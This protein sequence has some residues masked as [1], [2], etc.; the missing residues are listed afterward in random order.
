MSDEAT[1][2]TTQEVT[3]NEQV[4]TE[5]TDLNGSAY[6]FDDLDSLTETRNS[7]ELVDDAKQF[8][9]KGDATETAAEEGKS[10]VPS[11]DSREEKEAT[12][13]ED[14]AEDE[15]IEEIKYRQGKYGE[16]EQQIAEDTI[17]SQKIE[18]EEV[19]VSLKDLL[20][21]YA[22]KVP[23]DKRFNE[24]NV[25]KKE[26]EKSKEEY[27]TEKEYIN[28]YI[29]E[30][31]NKMREGK[32]VEALGFLAEF[33]GM[34]PYEF[35]QQL[36][37]NLAPEVDRRRTLSQDQLSNE[38]LQEE[39]KYLEQVHEAERQNNERQQTYMELE[40]KISALQ[41]TYDISDDDFDDAYDELKE[42]D[43]KD[44]LNP[45]LIVNYLRH[46]NAFTRADVVINEVQP[47]LASNQYVVDAIE[48][49]IF[50]N[51]EFTKEQVTGIVKEIYGGEQM[52]ASKAVSKKIQSKSIEQPVRTLAD[53][54]DIVDFD[55]I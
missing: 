54:E 52:K 13:E 44:Q 9:E 36:I 4:G 30:F 51:P 39:N 35:K 6:S 7:Q 15:V 43:L 18:G 37:Q 20:D 17:F 25:S 11:K 2:E 24:L 53:L 48:K 50:D 26:Y 21:N 23:Y 29:G 33:A 1:V 40:Q 10:K 46:K 28:N 16:D 3:L 45:E 32:A 27:D 41:E 55:D 34:K 14:Q 47:S 12:V 19:D 22:G 38:Q 5:E 42:T 8:L 49:I 31:A